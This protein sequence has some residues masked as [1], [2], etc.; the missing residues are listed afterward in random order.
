MILDSKALQEKLR[1]IEALFAGATTPGERDAAANAAAHIKERL[2][3][4]EKADPA[5]EY[6]FALGD[7]WSRKLFLALTRRYGLKPY[8]HRGQ[9]Y[10][11][12]MLRVPSWLLKSGD[13]R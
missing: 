3:V 2:R 8:R 11:T 1:R 6:K 4:A 7:P 9:R 12:V 13:Q 5:V 10:T